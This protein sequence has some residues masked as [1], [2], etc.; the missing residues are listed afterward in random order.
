[1][2][3]FVNNMCAY[4]IKSLPENSPPELPGKLPTRT[5]KVVPVLTLTVTL[6]C[7][8]QLSNLQ[9]SEVSE[10]HEPA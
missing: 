4:H 10:E 8:P 6:N 1:M 5:Y 9:A 3:S 2:S 7:D